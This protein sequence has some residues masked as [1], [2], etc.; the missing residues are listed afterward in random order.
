MISDDFSMKIDYKNTTRRSVDVIFHE[1]VSIN[2][3]LIYGLQVT[4]AGQ[5]AIG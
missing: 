3:I 4:P 5:R 2:Q 1:N